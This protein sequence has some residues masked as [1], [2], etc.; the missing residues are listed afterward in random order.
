MDESNISLKISRWIDVHKEEILSD[1]K[2]AVEIPSV[3][4]PDSGTAPYGQ[5]CWEVLDCMLEAA[6]GYGFETENYHY[7]VGGVFFN[8]SA[9]CSPEDN[10]HSACCSPEAG[11]CSDDRSSEPRRSA[12]SPRRIGIWSH[13]DVVPAG[14]NWSFPPFTLTE[15]DG[16]LIGRGVQDNKCAAVGVLHAFRCISE[17]FPKLHYEYA[18]YMGC[19]E[20]NTMDDVKFFADRYEQPDLSLVADCGFPVCYGE[21]G[22]IDVC[23][24]SERALP[25]YLLDFSAGTASNTIPDRASATLRLTEAETGAEAADSAIT[26]SAKGVSAHV[27]A[28]ERGKNAIPLLLEKLKAKGMAKG[29][30][31]W[32]DFLM[33]IS[34]DG[35]GKAA[36]IAYSDEVSGALTG[37]ATRAELSN[38]VLTVCANYRYPIFDDIAAGKGIAV[39][40]DNSL[41]D[42]SRLLDRLEALAGAH[43][44][45]MK[46]AKNSKPSYYEPD[47]AAVTTL[48][49]AFNRITGLETKAYTMSGGSYARQLDNAIAFGMSMP[50][51]SI[52]KEY[53]GDLRGDYHQANESLNIREYLK[54]IEIYIQCILELDKQ[55][56]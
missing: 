12:A 6:K 30:E 28:P 35:Y 39:V 49:D 55:E 27:I 22:I 51:K 50:G 47:S 29:D 43:G 41:S 18:L 26:V 44:F 48:T 3:S 46:V 33:K 32:F 5:P 10:C 4:E 36:G 15:K 34:A 19:S 9:N 14:D 25:D 1:L 42:G 16:F 21:K 13:L 7:H 11:F 17:L 56:I 24:T 37:T 8:R 31:D 38:G 45:S 53:E 52:Y 23:F 40:E 20:E 2:K 54:A